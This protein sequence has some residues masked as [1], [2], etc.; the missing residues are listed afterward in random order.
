MFKSLLLLLVCAGMGAAQDAASAVSAVRELTGAVKTGDMSWMVDKMYPQLRDSLKKSEGGEEKLREMF[1]QAQL[2]MKEAN[3][4][5]ES[6]EVLPPAGEYEVKQGTEKLVIVPTRTIFS[7]DQA[8]KKVRLQQNGFLYAI[9]KKDAP[10]KW[11]FLA[12]NPNLN[13]I[14]DLIHD[15]PDNITLPEVNTKPLP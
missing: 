2:S 9:A 1:R 13:Q 8:G 6:F 14:R 11:Y 15:L 7:M 4:V 10:D 5:V 3:F 12:G